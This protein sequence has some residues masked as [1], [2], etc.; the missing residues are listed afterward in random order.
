MA[1]LDPGEGYRLL[2]PGERRYKGDQILFIQRDTGKIKFEDWNYKYWLVQT[3]AGSP[4]RRKIGLPTTFVTPCK[5]G[6]YQAVK[7]PSGLLCQTCYMAIWAEELRKESEKEIPRVIHNH[8]IYHDND[9]GGKVIFECLALNI[10][11]ADKLFENKTGIKAVK[12]SNIGC[13][14][15][16]NINEVSNGK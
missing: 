1:D 10:M 3:S 12:A 15:A 5:C 8:Y 14:I 13:E 11:E 6:S 16:T 9:N 7:T 4:C 2:S